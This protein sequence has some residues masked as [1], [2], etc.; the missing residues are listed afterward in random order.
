M[1]KSSV[2]LLDGLP[3]LLVN[4]EV[5]P[6][7]AYM[8]YFDERSACADFARIGYKLYSVNISL[9]RRPINAT[10]SFSPSLR[11]IFDQQ[12]KMNLSELDEAVQNILAACPDAMIFPRIFITMPECWT[13]SHPEDVIRTADGQY[14]EKLGSPAFRRDGGEMLR[15]FIEA[16]RSSSY[17]E[18]IV[19]YQLAGGNTQ[20]WFHFDLHGSG[21]KGNNPTSDECR[22]MSY[23]VADTIAHFANIAKTAVNREQVVGVFYGYSLEVASPFHG[24]HALSRLI[25]SPDIDFFCSPNSY[26]GT[27]SLDV[28]WGDMIP[29]DSIQ[30]HGKLTF[31]ECDI[32]TCFSRYPEDCR[33]GSDPMRHYNSAIWVG[34]PTVEKS[35]YAIRKSFSRQLTHGRGFWWFDMWG[36]WYDHPQMMDEMAKM[37]QIA[38]Q[39]CRLPAQKMAEVAVF[40]DET[41][42]SRIEIGTRLAE[43]ANILRYALGGT[44]IPYDL[45][46][47]DDFDAQ[48]DRYKAVILPIPS[49]SAQIERAEA[50]CREKNI[51]CLR[52]TPEKFE[53]SSAELHDYLVEAGIWCYSTTLG[54]I[55]YAGNGY[56][57][58][59]AVHPGEKVVLLHHPYRITPLLGIEGETFVSDRIELT[60]NHHECVLWRIEESE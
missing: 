11:G 25:D 51:F 33:P 40:V 36:G 56:L 53:F 26:A 14:R 31:M 4:G 35:I 23:D 60:L 3:R 49:S 13:D 22:Q 58:L 39:A 27:R 55:V 30:A 47:L 29:A 18:N 21:Y 7:A 5:I 6:A 38:R 16:V 12:G 28:D 45:Y 57:S 50:I 54:D 43:T 19:G 46:L 17:A 48:I 41:M 24:T 9:V 10:T 44:G 52:C 15:R 37:E 34:P 42:S 59:H 32:R 1:I 8:T 2:S 20:E